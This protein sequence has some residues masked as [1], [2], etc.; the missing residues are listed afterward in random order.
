MLD[1]LTIFENLSYAGIF[2]LLMLVNMSP[3]LMPPTW[4]ILGSF[5]ILNDSYSPIALAIVGATGAT[6]GRAFLLQGSSYFRRFIGE[7]RKTSLDKLGLYL[8]SKPL[9]FFIT[10]L[11]FAATPLPSNFLFIGYGLM[12]ARNFQI[13]CG[14]W[15][16]RSISYFVMIKF[17]TIVLMPFVKLFEDRLWGMILIDGIGILVFL[18]FTCVNWNLLLSERKLKFVRPKLWK[19]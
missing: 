17:S 7:E 10:S 14:F 15:I 6:A 5:Y 8:Q 18:F 13:F 9:G 16:G 2:L 3:I 19:L 1:I 11:L 12:K 4:I